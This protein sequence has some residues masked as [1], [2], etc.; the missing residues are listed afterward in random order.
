MSAD[1]LRKK[2]TYQRLTDVEIEPVNW[3]WFERIALGK[4]T[5][6]AGQPG[7]G[8]TQC[9][10]SIAAAVSRGGELPGGGRAPL[11]SVVFVSAEDD[12]ADTI[13]PRLLAVGADVDKV[14]CLDN[15][16]GKRLFSIPGD[17]HSLG[18]LIES[19]FPDCKLVVIDP[20]S[21]YLGKSDQNSNGDMR[22]ALFPLKELAAELGFAVL[23]IS[24][25]NKSNDQEA[26][27]RISGSGALV[28]AARAGF[29]VAK[30]N[31][32]PDS[33]RLFLPVKNNLGNDRT[34][35]EYEITGAA[36]AE[37]ISTSRIVW[38]DETD[39]VIDDVLGRGGSKA[40][41]GKQ[42]EYTDLLDEYLD[43]RCLIAASEIEDFAVQ[44]NM[45]KSALQRSK[46]RL[47]YKSEKGK[48]G[49]KGWFWV[50]R[51]EGSK[52]SRVQVLAGET[53]PPRQ[54]VDPGI[55]QTH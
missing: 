9:A 24:H 5:V 42:D 8:K 55:S 51:G 15:E 36:V 38:G 21:A 40:K 35:F 34:G 31:A 26:I 14:V 4:L 37:G 48:K 1:A 52:N 22:A 54:E 19:D 13:K 3:L 53:G 30:D 44:H 23:L 12:I 46:R 33:K 10:C 17:L 43:G 27:N 49:E 16:V 29:V 32:E 45:P 2:L 11:G 25:L 39:N 47:G 41:G 18:R 20:V 6:L 50:K 28:A 7:L